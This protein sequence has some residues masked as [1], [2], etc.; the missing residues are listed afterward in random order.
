MASVLGEQGARAVREG[1][2]HSLSRDRDDQ[3]QGRGPENA[4]GMRES[5]VDI[6]TLAERLHYHVPVQL[7][8]SHMY[9]CIQTKVKETAFY[10]E[11]FPF[12]AS[13]H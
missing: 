1:A 8:S 11:Q 12:H 13:T 5:T 2:A 3:T 7:L 6:T 10:V 4:V 9:L